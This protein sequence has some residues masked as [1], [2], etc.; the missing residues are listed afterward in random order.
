[1]I[2]HPFCNSFYIDLY[3]LY[4]KCVLFTPA[5]STYISPLF[6]IHSHRLN[7]LF[8]MLHNEFGFCTTILCKYLLF[9]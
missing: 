9:C 7:H 2:F 5:R 3:V 4:S 6:E 1:M 8:S